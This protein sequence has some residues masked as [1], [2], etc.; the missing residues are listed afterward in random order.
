M[1]INYLHVNMENIRE[2][3]V[4]VPIEFVFDLYLLEVETWIFFKK[5]NKHIYVDTINHIKHT[6]THTHTHT[7]THTHIK[8][9]T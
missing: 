9:H 8:T 1:D 3:N 2:K 6:H 4:P 5:G 7:Y